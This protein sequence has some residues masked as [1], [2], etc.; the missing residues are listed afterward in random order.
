MKKK[1]RRF[2]ESE[3]KIKFIYIIYLLLIIF[4]I[5]NI[6]IIVR[7]NKTNGISKVF[8]VKFYCVISG[9]MEPVISVNDVIIIKQVDD[10]EIKKGD[11]ITFTIN[12]ETITH[13]VVDVQR[14][15]DGYYYITKGESNNTNDSQKVM[16]KNVEG[17]YIYKIPKIGRIAVMLQSK[18]TL[19]AVIG[20]IIFLYILDKKI[21]EKRDSKYK[22]K[23]Y[24]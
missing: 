7:S 11:I 2:K 20:V 14:D 4:L 15:K 13:R 22:A 6:T 12:N 19:F 3:H 1:K 8:G 17:K 18:F 16:Y 21:T 9:S 24:K 10:D 23:R 5:A